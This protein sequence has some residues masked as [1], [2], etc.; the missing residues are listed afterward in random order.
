[1]TLTQEQAIEKIRKAG[2]WYPYNGISTA[3]IRVLERLDLVTV[4]WRPATHQHGTLGGQ[5]GARGHWV[6]NWVARPV[7]AS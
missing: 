7:K 6:K 1:M 5:D 2:A 4:D 3:T